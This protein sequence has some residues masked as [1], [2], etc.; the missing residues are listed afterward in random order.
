MLSGRA[1]PRAC[2]GKRLWHNHSIC[3]TELGAEIGAAKTSMGS[4]AVCRLSRKPD[5][6]CSGSGM[7]YYWKKDQKRSS[8]RDFVP[9]QST[10]G[11][12]SSGSS[13]GPNQIRHWRSGSSMAGLSRV[14]VWMR[15]ARLLVSDARRLQDGHRRRLKVRSQFEL[16]RRRRCLPRL[17]YPSGAIQQIT[18]SMV[19]LHFCLSAIRKMDSARSPRMDET[20]AGSLVPLRSRLHNRVLGK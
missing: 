13:T 12:W 14:T 16:N 20:P 6:H 17:A 11:H 4:P 15:V 9:A 10:I 8:I 3:A 5:E 18:E 7:D 2:L 19:F 1:V